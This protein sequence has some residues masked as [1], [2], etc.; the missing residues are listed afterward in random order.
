MG[1]RLKFAAGMVA[2]AVED[3]AVAQAAALAARSARHLRSLQ[4]LLDLEA[5]A[6]VIGVTSAGFLPAA[7]ITTIIRMTIPTITMI[8]RLSR[9]RLCRWWRLP[10]GVDRAWSARRLSPSRRATLSRPPALPS[11]QASQRQTL[12]FETRE[13][14]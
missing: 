5:T 11:P 10:Q 8:P 3:E 1:S 7:S 9:S 2:A 12:R 14:R 6:L 13:V 4:A